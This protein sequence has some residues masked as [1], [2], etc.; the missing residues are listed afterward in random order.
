MKESNKAGHMETFVGMALAGVLSPIVLIPI[1]KW[2][3]GE[4]GNPWVGLLAIVGLVIIMGAILLYFNQ[5]YLLVGVI[6]ASILVI[7]PSYFALWVKVRAKQRDKQLV[8]EQLVSPVVDMKGEE[9]R[10][11]VE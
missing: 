10:E 4:S 5:I 11:A 6:F 2:S 9:K 7:T 1:W 3:L 8:Q